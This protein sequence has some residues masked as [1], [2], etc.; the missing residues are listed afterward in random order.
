METPNEMRDKVV[1]KANQ[2][3]DFR[4][5]EPP[6]E[7]RRVNCLSQAWTGLRSPA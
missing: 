4:A 3:A 7:T 6:R 1:G 5:R 2:D